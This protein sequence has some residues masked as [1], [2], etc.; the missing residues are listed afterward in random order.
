MGTQ[1]PM[2]TS[3]TQQV[4]TALPPVVA[5]IDWEAE[6]RGWKLSSEHWEKHAGELERRIELSGKELQVAQAQTAGL[7]GDLNGLRNDMNNL[8]ATIEALREENTQLKATPVATAATMRIKPKEPPIFD[9]TGDVDEWRDHMELYFKTCG[10]F[11]NDNKVT[12]ALPY[13]Q[14]K[15]N[16]AVTDY[17]EK[18]RRGE[19]LGAWDDMFTRI[20]R[21][22]VTGDEGMAAELALNGIKCG[23]DS[24][25]SY[26]ARFN[27]LAKKAG[28]ADSTLQFNYFKGLRVGTQRGVAWAGSHDSIGAMQQAAL[29][30]EES[31]N[32]LRQ[33]GA[34]GGKENIGRATATEEKPRSGSAVAPAKVT[35]NTIK[36]DTYT[37][38][39]RPT[40]TPYTPAP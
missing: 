35:A 6:A 12:T 40:P 4:A 39:P 3:P 24:I 8:R 15:A 38:A 18:I 29:R 36:T 16:K 30:D 37:P 17:Y 28:L 23:T 19:D 22:F 32:L 14:G 9:G 10:A 5:A 31:E 34:G 26:N 7:R 1:A 20:R 27:R 13:L 33:C 2:T 21:H 25:P 11:T